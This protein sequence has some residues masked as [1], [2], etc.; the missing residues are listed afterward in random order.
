MFRKSNLVL[1]RLPEIAANLNENVDVISSHASA[2]IS[3]N[4]KYVENLQPCFSAC[5]TALMT[6]CSMV[7]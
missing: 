3:G 5:L 2:N 4:I 6:G 1:A 7:T